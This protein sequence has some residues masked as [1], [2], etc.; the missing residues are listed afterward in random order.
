MTCFVVL[1][2]DA[3]QHV[4][5]HALRASK[6]VLDSTNIWTLQEMPEIQRWEEGSTEIIAEMLTGSAGDWTS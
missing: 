3:S 1:V 5:L 4:E 6:C 2:Q